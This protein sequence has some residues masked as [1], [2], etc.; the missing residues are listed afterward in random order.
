MKKSPSPG[1]VFSGHK[2]AVEISAS[3]EK[4]VHIIHMAV[5][6][7]AGAISL[8]EVISKSIKV[9]LETEFENGIQGKAIGQGLKSPKGEVSD[10]GVKVIGSDGVIGIP[11]QVA[12]GGENRFEPF[13]AITNPNEGM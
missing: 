6:H 13:A 1:T 2:M 10:L 4:A 11:D 9:N 12:N 7:I 3:K 5:K 8:R